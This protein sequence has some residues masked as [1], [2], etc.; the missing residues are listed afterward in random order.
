M[1]FS[2]PTENKFTHRPFTRFIHLLNVERKEIF[3]VYIYAIFNGFLQLSFPLGIQGIISLLTGAQLSTSWVVLVSLVTI[4]IFL[5]GI[6][7]LMQQSIIERLQQRI[8]TRAA[9]EFTFRFEHIA[10]NTLGQYYPSSL[11]NRFFDIL[12]IQKG[13]PKLLIDLSG[14][15]LQ[16]LFGLILL[17]FYH[18]FFVF[19][20][21]L[22]VAIL[23]FIL[24]ITWNRALDSSLLESKYKYK[25]AD[26]LDE[27][28]RNS[29][30]FK[31]A[32]D[33]ELTL[34]HTDSL[35][36]NYLK[37]RKEHFRVLVIQFFN[38]NL[39][40]TIITAGLLILGSIL[41]LR[42]EI[43][44]GQFVA[45]EIIIL[46][47]I[48]SSEKL[49]S[50]V[51]T[52]FDVLTSVEKMGNVTD[53]Q[54]ENNNGIPFSPIEKEK[55]ISISLQK[56]SFYYPENKQLILNKL[57]ATIPA[58]ARIC[59]SG[60]NNTGKSTLL[61]ILA[62]VYTHNEG[63]LLYNDLPRDTFQ[64]KSLRAAMG[65][66]SQNGHLFHGTVSENIILG[67]NHISTSLL[68]STLERLDLMSFIQSLP[69]GFN[70]EIP[71]Q[72]SGISRSII[73][74][75]LLARA[76]IDNP[77]LLLIDNSLEEIEREELLKIMEDLAHVKNSW[78][79]VIVS[80]RPL[81]AAQC[82]EIWVMEKGELV[83]KNSYNE[84]VQD[85][86]FMN[87]FF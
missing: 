30:S 54:V 12:S 29:E 27:S 66:V 82:Q 6:L 1:A 38:F 70:S 74:K 25:I 73:R 76:I 55:G 60:H 16:F 49:I 14:A 63:N 17:S 83:A 87:L 26:W 67:R 84:L 36:S 39:F 21:F 9:F 2:P 85:A 61:R 56:L 41:V 8:F 13:L 3:Y 42:Q 59:I 18:S 44:L 62:S 50:C 33:S 53:I 22:M 43:N 47:V 35:V 68:I 19:F 31:Y 28:L 75:I 86:R 72:G 57:N 65:L 11:A 5:S 46:L 64:L 79:L 81:I 71:P 78:T 15:V 32:G 4:G 23:I 45:S 80:N 51:E 77:Q 40:K 37:A 24:A 48:S 69:Q 7:Q 10:Q 34:K 20:G 58:R 52:L